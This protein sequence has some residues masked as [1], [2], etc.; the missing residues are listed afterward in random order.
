M[1]MYERYDASLFDVVKKPSKYSFP[2]FT[3]D[4]SV[5]LST[6]TSDCENVLSCLKKRIEKD[7]MSAKNS[8]SFIRMYG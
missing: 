3:S 1:N 8:G 4:G 5:V 6:S 2:G 7:K